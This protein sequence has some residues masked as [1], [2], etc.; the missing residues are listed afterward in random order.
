MT[1]TV[2]AHITK[3]TWSM[4]EPTDNPDTG[5]SATQQVIC[6]GPGTTAPAQDQLP[7]DPHD[8]NPDCGYTYHW[9]SKKARTNGTGR[10]P[11]SATVEWTADW[12]SNIGVGG[13]ITLAMDSNTS[14]EVGEL[15]A[16]MVNDPDANLHPGG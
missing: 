15:R 10:W 9:V 11:V 5:S 6:D 4:G 16:V 3:V 13:S 8:W 2:N 14:V 1:V 7:A 12:T